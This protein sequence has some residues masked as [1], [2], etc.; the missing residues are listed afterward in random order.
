MKSLKLKLIL[1]LVITGLA[2][3]AL[4]AVT[5]SWLVN[6]RFNEFA[7]DSAFS[8]F[9]EDVTRYIGQ[10]GSWQEAARFEP[11][12]AYVQRTRSIEAGNL[13]FPG[14]EGFS[15]PPG[16]PGSRPFPPPGGR[17]PR[18]GSFPPATSFQPPVDE[19]RPNP[20]PGP[21]APF[22]FM[23]VDS[24]GVVMLGAAGYG[25]GDTIPE[26]VMKETRA[27]TVDGK[28]VAYA[29]PVGLPNLGQDDLARLGVIKEA[30]SYGLLAAVALALFLG[31]FLGHRLVRSIKELT[32]AI[33]A[34][35]KGDLFQKVNVHSQ[36][37]VGE[38]A[39]SF[40][41]MS[42]D[43]HHAYQKLESSNRTISHQAEQLKELSIRDELTQLYNRRYFNEHA[44]R[45][46]SESTRY[47][48][49]LTLVIGDL[50]HFKQIND[51]F[52]HAVGDKVLQRVGRLLKE[53][54]RDSD[55][56]ARY[57]GE[58]FVI[59]YRETSLEKAVQLC[60]R[61]REKM[62]SVDWAEIAEGL[63]V[64]CSMGI[65]SNTALGSYEQMLADADQ[66]L[67]QAKD[68]GRNQVCY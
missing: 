12:I 14:R 26:S 11:F 51:R 36:D 25:P 43:L 48:H 24:A 64:R 28:T 57:G 47:G 45:M 33:R 7:M 61:L 41:K 49:P 58:E 59:A 65:C 46:H 16:P 66:K 29:H 31:L 39:D 4:V 18:A 37:E 3:I 17:P 20:G 68:Q 6:K 63:D 38:L 23:L 40:N 13:R 55:V 34:M 67:Y 60:E 19:A 30:L 32:R 35:N 50:D 10:Y 62:E 52:S 8:H 9:H 15:R 1:A 21:R 27:V 44:A 22:R 5:A 2:T 56:V 53:T 54:T 42:E